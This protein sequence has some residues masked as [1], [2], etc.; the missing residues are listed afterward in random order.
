MSATRRSTSIAQSSSISASSLRLASNRSARCARSSGVNLSAS[1]S[2]SSSWLDMNY[3]RTVTA[4]A[5][6]V[7][8]H[9]EAIQT[10][11]TSS[12]SSAYCELW[13]LRS[14]D[15]RG[16]AYDR[17]IRRVTASQGRFDQAVLS[18]FQKRNDLITRDP[19]ESIE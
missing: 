16:G 7:C 14:G 10:L 6:I 4:K 18:H 1:A 5:C 17:R 2:T 13:N 9:R 15:G 3:L 19:R 12:A 8:W 11:K